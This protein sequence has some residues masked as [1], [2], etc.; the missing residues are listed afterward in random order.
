VPSL[1][2]SYAYC[3]RL[4]R[5]EARNFYPAFRLLPTDQRRA[6]CALYAFLRIADDLAD[7]TGSLDSRR[8][9]LARW[10]EQFHDALAGHYR[11]PLHPALRD[12]LARFSVPPAY[13]EAVLDGVAMDLDT[14][15]YATF[16][17]LYSYCYRVAS[18]VGLACIHVWGFTDPRAL[19]HA[20][21]AGIAFQLTNILRDL[22]EDA[23]RD[24]I[25]LPAED[26]TRFGY[27]ADRLRRGVRD[28][29]FHALMRFEVERA[30]DYYARAAPLAELLRPA[31]RA[32]FLVLSRTYA[33]LL[34]AIVRRDYDVFSRRVRLGRLHKLW[35]AASAL[36]VRWGWV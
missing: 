20:E 2:G 32:V 3:E 10:R 18:A 15:R 7:G 29:A 4:A 21:A 8:E 25:Y 24:R 23:A 34:D 9:P 35:L 36:P 33:G 31:G 11:H 14:Q 5:R 28:D 26:L 1:G 17:D 13:L 27:D 30:R 6:L 19:V 22:S 12:T 16:D